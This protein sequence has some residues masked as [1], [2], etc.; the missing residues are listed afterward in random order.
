MHKSIS[1][2]FQFGRKSGVPVPLFLPVSMCIL[3]N[4]IHL[5]ERDI[6]QMGRG[7]RI[8]SVC[9]QASDGVHDIERMGIRF[10][11]AGKTNGL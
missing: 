2:H 10:S 6:V 11:R 8:D 4:D 3:H 5:S 9:Y 1:V 7:R